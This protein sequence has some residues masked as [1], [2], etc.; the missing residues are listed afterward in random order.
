MKIRTIKLTPEALVE[1]MQGKNPAY[2]ANLPADMELLDIKLDLYT[3]QVTA[4]IHSATFEDA[5]TDQP[6]PEYEIKP[7]TRT[8]LDDVAPAAPTPTPPVQAP[9]PAPTPVTPVAKVEPKPEPLA[10]RPT[11][12]QP[13]L[14][15]YAAKMENEFSPDQRKLLSFNVKDDVVVVKPIQFLKA[16]W[17]DINE[18]VRSLGGR[19]VKGDIVSYWAIPLQ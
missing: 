8:K 18:T 4:V 12:T 16:E 7:T 15:R 2:A 11:L 14:N 19:W 1:L 6:T 17:D 3:K 5:P 9:E 13:P 10:P